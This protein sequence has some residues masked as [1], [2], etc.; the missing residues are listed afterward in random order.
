M[1]DNSPGDLQ[2][3]AEQIAES[4]AALTAELNELKRQKKAYNASINENIKD[5]EEQIAG[6]EQQW[7]TLRGRA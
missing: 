7:K 5:I 3:S 2:R 6:E 1:A 4:I